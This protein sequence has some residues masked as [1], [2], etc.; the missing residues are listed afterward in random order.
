M[1]PAPAGSAPPAG[2]HWPG[3]RTIAGEQVFPAC[4]EQVGA[5]RRFVARFLAG[6]P[7]AA[8]AILC[9]S[10]LAGNWR[11]PGLANERP[12]EAGPPQRP[13]SGVS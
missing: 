1:T 13:L 9:V 3:R 12:S 8:D 7:V 2:R 10:E 4:P 6:A 5:A 11:R